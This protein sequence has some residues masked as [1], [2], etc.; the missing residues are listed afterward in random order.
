MSRRPAAGP[1]ALVVLVAL[2]AVGAAGCGDD[3]ATDPVAETEAGLRTV[4]AGRLATDA[5]DVAVRCPDDVEVVVGTAFT[6]SVAVAGAAPFDVDLGVADDGTVELRKAVIPT[7]DAEAYLAEKLAGPAEGPVVPDC[8]DAPVL[9]AAVGDELRCQVVRT[10]DGAT[11]TVVLTVLGLDGNVR[12]RV[13]PVVTT[14]T[15][16]PAPP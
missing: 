11:S 8:G 13:E 16:V 1:V 5:G 10:G 12:Y 6:C 15:T 2:A 3:E 14:T 9:V 7:A 4:R